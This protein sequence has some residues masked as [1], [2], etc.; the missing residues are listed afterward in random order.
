VALNRVPCPECGAGLKSPSGFKVGQN[1]CCP[2]CETYFTVEEP[3]DDEA[4]TPRKAAA[5]KAGA[6]GGK[7][8]VKAAAVADDDDDALPKK[9]KKRAS[10][11]DEDE[12]RSYKNSPARYAVLGVLVV[13]MIGLGVM[14]ILKKREEAK[15]DET[16]QKPPEPQTFEKMPGELP[17]PKLLAGAGGGGLG[18]PNP[19]LPNPKFPNPKLPKP[20]DGGG[21]ALPFL[22]G[23]GALPPDVA[24]ARLN[25][26]R[27]KIVGTWKADL[28][29][30]Q[31]SEVVYRADGTFTDTLTTGGTPKTVS[32]TWTAG[33]LVSGNKG[34]A[35][36]RT[37]A[38]ART[39]VK[40]VF[41]DDELLH[42]TQERGL[43]G[44]FRK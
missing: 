23:G 18:F 6:S 7:K 34:I 44:V 11:D 32:G 5:G 38:G 35:I 12:G 26:Y 13:V 25:Q 17:D 1:V 40:A 30:G 28:G 15:Q 43:T 9:K 21:F 22:D 24:A 36:T 31:T 10:E 16:V 42:D 3:A 4:N 8:P 39:T 33:G 37:V 14:L 41:E 19:K 29:R 2:K 27:T 20:P